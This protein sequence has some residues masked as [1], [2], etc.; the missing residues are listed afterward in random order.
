VASWLQAAR[1]GSPQALGALL[2]HFRHYLLLVA[3]H[4]LGADVQAKVG[5]SDVVQET[6]LRA[7]RR[8]SRFQGRTETDLR[9]W[10]RRILVNQ[11]ANA[12]R[13]YRGA[14]KRQVNRELSPAEAPAAAP[15]D[16]L[17]GPAATPGAA[18]VGREQ[19]AALRQ[20]LEGL[21]EH[22]RQAVEW[23][24]FEGLSFA[25]IGRQLGRS[26][27][28]ARMVWAR[29]VEQLGEALGPSHDSRSP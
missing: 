20:A 11:L 1:Q 16:A 22:Y 6:L 14:A 18:A 26:A 8:F 2:E 13:H 23:R 17:A 15:L 12:Q 5:P 10:L 24:N 29:A 25:E 7:H 28:A 21:P 3:N 4:R 9:R 19:E 27:E